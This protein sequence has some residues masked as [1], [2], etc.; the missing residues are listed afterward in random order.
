LTQS[1]H[2]LWDQSSADQWRAAD[3]A[4]AGLEVHLEG[5]EL[6]DFPY[7]YEHAL[8]SV[9]AEA[10]HVLFA[11]HSGNLYADRKRLTAF[12]LRHGMRSSFARREYVE[13][14]GLLSYG[15]SVIAMDRRAAEYIDRIARGAK[16]T[17]LPIEQPTE[18]ELVLNLKTA[19]AL[20]LTIP[21]EML[22][23]ADKVIEQVRDFRK[24]HVCG[25]R[26]QA[27]NVCFQPPGGR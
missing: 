21:S 17:D 12:A 22:V 15:A 8:D 10:R 27:M 25:N 13:A 19:K 5:A 1:R 26:R 14:G 4:S 24:W 23:R 18:F 2:V 20:G 3:N 6:H 9:P 16:T 7:D 11:A